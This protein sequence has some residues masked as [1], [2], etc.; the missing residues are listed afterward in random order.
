M[1]AGFERI[2]DEHG[3]NTFGLL[4][5]YRPVHNLSFILSPGITL[6]DA[7]PGEPHFALHVETAYEFVINK[8]HLGPVLEFAY[9]PE[10][11]HISLGLHIGFG[12]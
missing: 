12:F 3:H 7:E 8:L 2:F 10:D 5:C 6:E 11:F 1:G 4:A 9:D